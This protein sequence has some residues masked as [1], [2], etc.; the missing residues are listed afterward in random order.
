MESPL[1]RTTSTSLA[2]VLLSQSGCDHYSAI[3]VLMRRAA[4]N[5]MF[6]LILAVV[7]SVVLSLT[8]SNWLVNL[9]FSIAF[10]CGAAALLP[11]IRLSTMPSSSALSSSPAP[12][13]FFLLS[14]FSSFSSRTA[15]RTSLLTSLKP[16]APL[17]TDGQA[18]KIFRDSSSPQ[19]SNQKE[20]QSLPLGLLPR[21][22]TTLGC[23]H[24]S[25][26]HDEDGTGNKSQASA[27]AGGDSFSAEVGI[28]VE[29]IVRDFVKNWYTLFTHDEELP[30]AIAA[31]LEKA[32][33][34][35][36]FRL[37]S[38]YCSL[39]WAALRCMYRKER[40]KIEKFITLVSFSTE[41]STGSQ[42]RR[43]CCD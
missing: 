43:R 1:H 7:I 39:S 27:A 18:P 42:H 41:N 35:V 14:P 11:P 8:S 22:S 33:T 38:R 21:S 2:S 12:P 16:S 26:V 9:P 30:T 37:V 13:P 6:G 19:R 32:I 23:S 4:Q 17:F 25:Y 29:L 31:V 28:L 40:E 20:S 10:L 34:L 24:H 15:S 5:T 36:R 3:G